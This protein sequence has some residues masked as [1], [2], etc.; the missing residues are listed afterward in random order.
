MYFIFRTVV[1]DLKL[2]LATSAMYMA[3]IALLS[4][5][6]VFG[7]RSGYEELNYE[8]IENFG[9]I[10]I[11]RYP[12]RLVAEVMDMKDK[13]TEFMTLFRYIAGANSS[14]TKVAMT[15]PVQV[16]NQGE[17]ITMTAPV[18]TS[19]AKEGKFSMRFF[20]PKTLN[21]DTAPKPTSPNIK[22]YSLPEET[23]AVLR[24]SGNSSQDYFIQQRAQLFQKLVI[25]NW[26][27]VAP[28]SF[29]GY[30]PPF[31]I[32]FLR[33]NEVAVQVESLATTP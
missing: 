2:R 14:R 8:V 12:Q 31:T 10:E 22:V 9:G 24:Y 26:K 18:E 30:D 16:K 11:R 20:L 29:L 25:S 27:A 13:N 32:P 15:S 17:K 23:Y 1:N 21:I 5:C 3:A 19:P 28:A 7:I 4:G 33:R 6:S